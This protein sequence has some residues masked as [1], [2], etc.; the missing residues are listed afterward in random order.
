MRGSVAAG[1]GRQCAPAAP[2]G[3]GCA[4]S[5][6]HRSGAPMSRAATALLATLLLA[7]R[8]SATP[9]PDSLIHAPLE[10]ARVIILVRVVES[11]PRSSFARV[12]VLKSWRGPFPAGRVL[13][14]EPPAACAGAG[15]VPYRFQA[16]DTELVIFL[17]DATDRTTIVAWRDWTWPAAESQALI[18]ALDQAGKE[19][20]ARAP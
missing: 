3:S 10:K 13:R 8:A 5:Q 20:G 16:A 19:A 11:R 14:V 18:A 4:A 12:Q 7:S 2:I 9:P 1:A 17:F 15:C 6:L